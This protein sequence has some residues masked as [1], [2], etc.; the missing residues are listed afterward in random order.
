MNNFKISSRYGTH[1]APILSSTTRITY[2]PKKIASPK[3]GGLS[4][5]GHSI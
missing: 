1:L 5:I 4:W 2:D 3:E